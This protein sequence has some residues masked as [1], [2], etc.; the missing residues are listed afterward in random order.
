MFWVPSHIGIKGNEKTDSLVWICLVPRLVY[1][2]M[3]LNTILT[4]IL[5][6]LDK[7]IGMVQ[8][9]TSFI[10]S[11]RSGEIGSPHT[12]GAGRMVIVLCRARIGQTH[13][14]HLY[15]LKKDPPPQC[16]HCQCIL[17]FR[18]MLV[19]CDHFA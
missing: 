14:I 15:I 19:D 8:S 10:L 4:N 17:T 13:L 9:R 16:E 2:I 12:G 6:P 11:S 3:I 7:M 5:F 18:H 1:P